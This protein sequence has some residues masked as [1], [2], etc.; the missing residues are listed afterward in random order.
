M[1][2]NV[3][4]NT[5]QRVNNPMKVAAAAI[6]SIIP[7]RTVLMMLVSPRSVTTVLNLRYVSL[8]TSLSSG[9]V[10]VSSRPG[11]LRQCTPT[12]KPS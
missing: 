11:Q 9:D 4:G 10:S 3:L 5:T 6:I 7:S 2:R 1:R 8:L 12:C